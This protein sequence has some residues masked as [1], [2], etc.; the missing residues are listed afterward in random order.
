MG[1][2]YRVRHLLL[3][4]EMALKTLR[5]AA[6]SCVAWQ[7][8]QREAQAIARL[9]H[10]N[11]VQVYD[12]G[13]C[14]GNVPYYTMELL[15]GQPLSDKLKKYGKLSLENALPIFKSVAAALSHA[16]CHDIVHRDIK[17]ANIFLDHSQHERTVVKVVDFGLAKLAATQ[18]YDGQA[19]TGSG[20][21]FGSP[22]YMSPEQATADETDWRTDIYSFG[23][24]FF[25]T[26]TGR[27]PFI[28]RTAFETLQ[29]HLLDVPPQLVEANRF[30]ET[31]QQLEK[32]MSK[33]L[34]KDVALRYQSFDDVL[35][36]LARL[37]RSST[38]DATHPMLASFPDE[39][40]D[41]AR[42]GLD[43][44]VNVLSV[45]PR[46]A[47]ANGLVSK[48]LETRFISSTALLLTAIMVS[49]LS[50]IFGPNMHAVQASKAAVLRVL[51][52][53]STTLAAKGHLL[54]IIACFRWPQV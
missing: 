45:S 26:L 4:K 19:T 38:C 12:C 18:D 25:E 3:N 41:V 47:A 40:E 34:A 37:E 52:F 29:M 35:R 8:F 1:S 49:V 28:G 51:P 44:Q 31:N 2:V 53:I 22:L 33:L 30:L 50:L 11:I 39:E 16:H 14:E 54:L 13:I 48:S 5:R 7:R 15:R 17:P 32:V 43:G 36:D 10:A 42:A 23:C 27:P 46:M 20:I 24:A 6:P 9:N 21:V